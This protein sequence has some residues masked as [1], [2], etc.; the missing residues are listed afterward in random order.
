MENFKYFW[1]VFV[2]GMVGLQQFKHVADAMLRDKVKEIN[3]KLTALHHKTVGLDMARSKI[4]EQLTLLAAANRAITQ[5]YEQTKNQLQTLMNTSTQNIEALIHTAK[6]DLNLMLVISEMAP[7]DDTRK[8]A[9]L[10]AVNSS[11]L[12]SVNA[13]IEKIKPTDAMLLSWAHTIRGTTLHL[14]G[15]YAA[16]LKDFETALSTKPDNTNADVAQYNAACA[17]ARLGDKQKA[18]DFIQQAFLTRPERRAE[19]LTDTDLELIWPELT[20]P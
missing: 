3:D 20:I 14:Q 4:D 19:A 6:A 15:K 8:Q 9:M 12:D 1:L 16:A 5:N 7:G 17:A 2:G 10:S 18:L 13:V 11:A